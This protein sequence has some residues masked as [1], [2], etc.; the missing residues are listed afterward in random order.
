MKFRGRNAHPNRPR[1]AMVCPTW[2]YGGTEGKRGSGGQGES[3]SRET[4]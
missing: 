4:G 3:C 1:K 2:L